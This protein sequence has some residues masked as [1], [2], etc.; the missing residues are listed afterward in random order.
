MRFGRAALFRVTAAA[1]RMAILT[2]N[3]PGSG[4]NAPGLAPKDQLRMRSGRLLQ[5]ETSRRYA[6]LWAGGIAAGHESAAAGRSPVSARE[7]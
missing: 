4:C 7:E 3:R 5:Q 2:V 6:R 1:A